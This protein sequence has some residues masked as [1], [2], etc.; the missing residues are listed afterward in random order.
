MCIQYRGFKIVKNDYM[1]NTI[2]YNGVFYLVNTCKIAWKYLLGVEGWDRVCASGWKEVNFVAKAWMDD[3]AYTWS[4]RK[5]MQYKKIRV[6]LNDSPKKS[7]LLIGCIRIQTFTFILKNTIPYN[8]FCNVNS[9][10]INRS[11]THVYAKYKSECTPRGLCLCTALG[12]IKMNSQP[13]Y[14]MGS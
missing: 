9:P 10:P 1:E 2:T 3:F 4:I 14:C 8:L 12:P 11:R 7:Q 13:Y 6:F 5:K